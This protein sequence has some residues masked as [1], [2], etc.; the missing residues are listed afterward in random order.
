MTTE[1]LQNL[2]AACL[3]SSEK[4]YL[5]R[6]WNSTKSD[7][8]MNKFPISPF[9]DP[10]FNNYLHKYV[11]WFQLKAASLSLF[12]SIM[13]TYPTSEKECSQSFE[14]YIDYHRIYQWDYAFNIPIMKKEIS[15]SAEF[16]SP[17]QPHGEPAMN[18]LIYRYLI[19]LIQCNCLY[20]HLA[21][22]RFGSHE[23]YSFCVS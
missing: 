5:L 10:V 11:F 20:S 22:F 19:K 23:L 8:K 13:Q 15:K 1:K 2:A 14:N 3:P 17:K 9:N 6:L 4:E 18:R 21:C 7:R 16:D 12:N